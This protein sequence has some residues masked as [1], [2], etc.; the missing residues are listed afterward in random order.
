MN[1][2]RGFL[3]LLPVECLEIY[4]AV[5]KNGDEFFRTADLLAEKNYFGKAITH[6]ILGAE[7]CIKGLCLLLEGHDFELRKIKEVHGIFKHHLPRHSIIRDT[8]SVWMVVRHIYAIKNTPSRRNILQNLLQAVITI[9]PAMGNYEWWQKA[10]Q[11]KQR[12]LYTDFKGSVQQPSDLSSEEYEEAL[13]RTKPVFKEVIKF[14]QKIS[15][16]SQ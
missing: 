9:F 16:M 4:P 13:R 7:E 3:D 10:D 2:N 6:L 11:L 12:G 5:M 1:S 14:A 8:Y 15:R